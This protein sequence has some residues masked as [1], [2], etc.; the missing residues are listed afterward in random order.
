[1]KNLITFC[2]FALVGI[3]TQIAIGGVPEIMM[4]V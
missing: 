3:L 2:A 4:S 1:M